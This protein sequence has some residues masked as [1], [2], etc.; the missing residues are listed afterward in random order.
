[1]NVNVGHAMRQARQ[2]ATY[3]GKIRV[4]VS[5]RDHLNFSGFRGWNI[6][7]DS[8]GKRRGRIVSPTSG[9]FVTFRIVCGIVAG[10][11]VVNLASIQRRTG[12]DVVRRADNNAAISVTVR[13]RRDDTGVCDGSKRDLRGMLGINAVLVNKAC[14]SRGQRVVTYCRARRVLRRPF[15]DH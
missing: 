15:A 12:L 4:D 10:R 9:N 14:C 6:V 5:Y 11:S 8:L 1:M 2:T 3:F 13:H 7:D